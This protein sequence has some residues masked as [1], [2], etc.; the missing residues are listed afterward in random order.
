MKHLNITQF[1]KTPI[2][3]SISLESLDQEY[4]IAT[5]GLNLINL[6]ENFALEDINSLKEKSKA[7]LLKLWNAILEII[8]TIKNKIFGIE[9][10]EE[11]IIKKT[12]DPEIKKATESIKK[13]TKNL[14]S[15]LEQYFDDSEKFKND[16]TDLT[17]KLKEDHESIK[18]ITPASIKEIKDEI[19]KNKKDEITDKQIIS[20]VKQL[21]DFFK[22]KILGYGE[23]ISDPKHYIYVLKTHHHNLFKLVD[24]AISNFDINKKIDESDSKYQELEK[25]YNVS[26]K[27]HEEITENIKKN[28]NNPDMVNK[29]QNTS[30]RD[31]FNNSNDFTIQVR[32]ISRNYPKGLGSNSLSY[33]SDFINTLKKDIDKSTDVQNSNYTSL[34]RNCIKLCTSIVNLN[35]R[36]RSLNLNLLTIIT[37][38]VSL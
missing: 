17:N 24:D 3:Q 34:L 2:V 19:N 27:I 5:S 10:K 22:G 29:L 21:D 38:S 8:N 15:D 33:Y 12:S 13:S 36:L 30:I 4:E 31:V 26:L 37:M 6:K 28:E 32:S 7:F 35:S 25:A 11:E 18:P 9:K 1:Q 23:I 16:I 20:S 14:M